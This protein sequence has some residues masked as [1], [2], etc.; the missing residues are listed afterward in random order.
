MNQSKYDNND[1][2]SSDKSASRLASFLNPILHI[3]DSLKANSAI[4]KLPSKSNQVVLDVGAGD[5]KFLYFLKKKGFK[6][7][8]TTLSSISKAAAKENFDVDLE[9]SAEL[10]NN[11]STRTYDLISYWHVYEHLTDPESH[12]SKWQTL[13]NNQGVLLIEVPNIDS[14]GAKIHFDSWLGSD[15]EHHCNL[16]KNEEIDSVI[17]GSGLHIIRREFFSL[18]FSYPFIWSALVGKLL[19]KKYDFDYIL[20]FLKNPLDNFKT[21]FFSS[22]NLLLSIFY[23]APVCLF[24][25]IL[26]LLKKRGEVYRVYAQKNS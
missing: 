12:V 6:V 5:G 4:S 26:G 11:I 13:L 7:Y 21:N 24:L 18:K 25:I 23:L 17:L 2:Y 1:Y 8:G 19:N 3:L 9:F 10:S 22:L 20:N 15:L 16:Q 14:Y